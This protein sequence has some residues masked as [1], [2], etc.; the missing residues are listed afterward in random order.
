MPQTV[1][2][3]LKGSD[4]NIEGRFQLGF[5]HTAVGPNGKNINLMPP[6]VRIVEKQPGFAVIELTCSCGQKTHVRCDYAEP[7]A[8]AEPQNQNNKPKSPNKK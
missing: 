2:R 4:V 6:Q 7:N 8:Q 5:A 3:I 1:A